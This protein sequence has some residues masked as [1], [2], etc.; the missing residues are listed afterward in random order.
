MPLN[1]AESVVIDILP[2]ILK[3]DPGLKSLSRQLSIKYVYR[4]MVTEDDLKTVGSRLWEALG[5]ADAIDDARDRA[6][7]RILPLILRA[8]SAEVLALPWECLHHPELGFL[9][10]HDGFTLCR[11]APGG[12][13]PIGDPPAGPLK[14]L[15]FTSLPD[16]LDAEKER[17]N[18][19]A[20]QE[21]V[22][23]ALDPWVREG[24]AELTCPDDGGFST[25]RDLMKR[26]FT[27]E[28]KPFEIS[29]SDAFEDIQVPRP[30]IG[31][32]MELRGLGRSLAAERS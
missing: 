14:V 22:I 18:T 15:L 6:G 2:G 17:L 1:I 31:R 11:R 8:E 21:N 10:K 3:Q 25:F 7:S 29:L 26:V 12:A 19:E 27:A 9:G 30:F 20:E 32:R 13:G 5:M 23:D 24:R 4:E 28:E 16:D